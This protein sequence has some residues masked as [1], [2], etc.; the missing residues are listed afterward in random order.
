MPTPCR[1]SP[2][3]RGELGAPVCY[4]SGWH[5]KTCHPIGNESICARAGLHVAQLQLPSTW[6]TCQWRST[7]THGFPCARGRICVQVPEW[8]G[9]ELLAA[10]GPFHTSTAGSLSTWLPRLCPHPSDKTCSLFM[11]FQC[12]GSEIGCF[13]DP[14]IRLRIRDGKKFRIRDELPRSLSE[15]LET[16]FLG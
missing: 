7:N 9:V 5:A 4:E 15:S 10:C 13:F 2:Y 3:S 14:G 1:T 11:F 16:V 8:H 6:L 12:C